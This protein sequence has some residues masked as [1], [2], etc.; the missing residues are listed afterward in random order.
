MLP[1]KYYP[2]LGHINLT[3]ATL[4]KKKSPFSKKV[5]TSSV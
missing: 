1:Y 4:A 3:T 2:F 5:G